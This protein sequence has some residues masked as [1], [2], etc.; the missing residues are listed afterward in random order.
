MPQST[1][2]FDQRFSP[3]LVVESPKPPS[4]GSELGW[5]GSEMSEGKDCDRLNAKEC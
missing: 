5:E 3:T 1:I 2:Y 4:N